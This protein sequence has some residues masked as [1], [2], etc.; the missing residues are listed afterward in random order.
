[1]SND[2]GSLQAT[3]YYTVRE[4]QERA[5]AERCADPVARDIHL[6]L[7][8]RYAAQRSDPLESAA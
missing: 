7:A 8:R 6:E 3:D 1:M 2:N 5:H 4:R